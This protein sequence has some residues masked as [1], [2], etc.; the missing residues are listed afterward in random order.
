ME[1]LN[2]A[3]G[4]V[5]LP[6]HIAIIMDGNGRWAKKRFLPRTAG[7]RAGVASV[8]KAIEYC[9]AQ[10]V[11]VLTLFAFSSENW[12]RPAQEVSVLMGLFLSTLEKETHKLHQN[13]VRLRVIGDR[14][15]FAA[16]LQQR[17][18]D[19][20]KLTAANIG[21]DLVIAANYG[22]RWDIAQAARR[23]AE[24]VVAGNLSPAAITEESLAS[25]L[26]LADLPEPDL[27][28]RTGGEQRISNFLLWQL[29][30]TE[31]Y[32]TETLWPD[33][34]ETELETAIKDYAGRQRRFGYTGEQ[35]E[36][37]FVNNG[38]G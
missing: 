35:V 20:E 2:Q 14:N 27:F 15:A 36:T 11:K 34:D 25:Y 8:R 4:F 31:L 23:M 13:N 5:Q 24:E 26:H 33:F 3:S 28:I 32:F 17:I 6:R 18:G 1:V 38:L 10:G 21:L 22:G 7:H 9:R 12:R 19:A 30:Y 29:A 16:E 37:L